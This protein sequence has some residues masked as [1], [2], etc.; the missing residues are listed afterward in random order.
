MPNKKFSVKVSE[1]KGFLK[2]YLLIYFWCIYSCPMLFDAMTHL[3]DRRL[4]SCSVTFSLM[5]SQSSLTLSSPSPWPRPQLSRASTEKPITLRGS[6]RIVKKNP[7]NHLLGPTPVMV[8]QTELEHLAHQLLPGE[9]ED[10]L[11]VVLR[12]SA[13]IHNSCAEL[14]IFAV[15]QKYLWFIKLYTLPLKI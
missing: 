4:L 5:S 2:E 8:C 1:E 7:D 10:E 13:V 3:S 14:K 6:S 11:L 9:S 12:V 15:K